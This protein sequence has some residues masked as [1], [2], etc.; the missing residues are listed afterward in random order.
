MG[1]RP[2][3]IKGRSGGVVH[4]RSRKQ[5]LRRRGVPASVGPAYSSADLIYALRDS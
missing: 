1:G 4:R 2:G 5:P 3:G